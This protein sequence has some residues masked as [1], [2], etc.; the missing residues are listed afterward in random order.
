[1]ASRII[2]AR[3]TRMCGNVLLV[4]RRWSLRRSSSDKM[5]VNSLLRGMSVFHWN[6]DATSSWI[7]QVFV[8]Q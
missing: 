1:M 2:P 3:V 8:R 7:T 4:T 6:W 5:L